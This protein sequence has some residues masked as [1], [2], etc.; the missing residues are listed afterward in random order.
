MAAFDH[1]TPHEHGAMAEALEVR[2]AIV[3]YRRFDH[4]T[5]LEEREVRTSG[6]HG[7]VIKAS[8]FW[9]FRRRFNRLP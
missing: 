9:R 8:V 4:P 2:R 5:T 1:L 3:F 7:K 6:P